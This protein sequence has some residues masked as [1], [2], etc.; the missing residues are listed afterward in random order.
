MDNWTRWKEFAKGKR[1]VS[2]YID[3]HDIWD[4]CKRFDNHRA[5]IAAAFATRGLS[6]TRW[7]HVYNGDGSVREWGLVFG[8]ADS[9]LRTTVE[10]SGIIGENLTER[11]SDE[12][13]TQS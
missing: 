1:V 2:I 4:K 10:I 9:D 11:T 7:A 6:V 12:S 8:R 13:D 3:E 5:F